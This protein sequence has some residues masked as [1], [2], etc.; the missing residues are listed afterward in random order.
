EYRTLSGTYNHLRELEQGLSLQFTRENSR[1]RQVQ[2]QI[3]GTFAQLQT[4]REKYPRL[5]GVTTQSSVA[6][7]L[8]QEATSAWIQVTEH[9]AKIKELNSQLERLRADATKL[10]MVEGAIVELRRKKELDEANYRYYAANLEQ[11]RISETLGN[12]KVSNI[13]QIQAAS[14]AF[15]EV[16]DVKNPALSLLGGIF[17]GVAWAF[18]IELFLDRSVRRPADLARLARIP[19]FL[20]IPR[21]RL[22]TGNSKSG[23]SKQLELNAP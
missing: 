7:P 6:D 12:G 23:R 22:G 5:A 18:L 10:E 20:S 17:A 19:L 3:A 9:Q 13:S 15:R 16:G 2:A 14:P 21:L 1:V 4:L 8:E 11:A